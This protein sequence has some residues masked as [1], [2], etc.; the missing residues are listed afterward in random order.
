MVSTK[1][2]MSSMQLSQIIPRLCDTVIALHFHLISLV[3]KTLN[4]GFQH[5]NPLWRCGDNHKPQFKLVSAHNS[6]SLTYSHEFIANF[7]N[8]SKHFMARPWKSTVHGAKEERVRTKESAAGS[9][10][11]IQEA[12]PEHFPSPTVPSR[13]HEARTLIKVRGRSEMRPRVPD[14]WQ[15]SVSVSVFCFSFDATST[16]TER[17]ATKARQVSLRKSLKK[18]LCENVRPKYVRR[19]TFPDQGVCVWCQCCTCAKFK[20][21]TQEKTQNGWEKRAQLGRK[22][23][24]T[25]ENAGKASLPHCRQSK[26]EWPFVAFCCCCSSYCYRHCCYRSAREYFTTSSPKNCIRFNFEKQ[27]KSNKAKR[28]WNWIEKRKNIKKFV[29]CLLLVS[30]GSQTNYKSVKR[31]RNDL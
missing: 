12:P 2:P 10:R 17:Q 3:F 26:I 7:R 8:Y 30:C 23:W 25:C 31:P 19:D 27:K 11:R 5:K 18:S 4:L 6:H 29:A 28:N 22:F 14:F 15:K 20:S 24:K 16:A 21:K 13:R 1:N 9:T